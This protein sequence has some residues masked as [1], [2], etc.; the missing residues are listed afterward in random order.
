[1]TE[2]T[3]P[4]IIHKGHRLPCGGRAGDR[5]L[6]HHDDGTPRGTAR[7]TDGRE[8]EWFDASRP[9]PPGTVPL[10]P[11]AVDDSPAR[12]FTAALTTP[13]ARSES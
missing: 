4:T 6:L 5:L 2:Q 1:M 8:L 12:Q 3:T 13:T 9:R 10:L 11:P 7:S